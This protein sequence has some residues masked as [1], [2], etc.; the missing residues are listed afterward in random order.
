M[1]SIIIGL[2]LDV[3]Y[4]LK[5]NEINREELRRTLL[6]L[7]SAELIQKSLASN[8]L[9]S[10]NFLNQHAFVR[11]FLLLRSKFLSLKKIDRQSALRLHNSVGA[12]L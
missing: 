4:F 2:S 12:Y 9:T 7:F 11:R 1:F 10:S 6:H 3:K 8:N 5:K